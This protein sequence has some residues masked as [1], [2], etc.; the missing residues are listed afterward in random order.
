MSWSRGI[1]IYLSTHQISNANCISD[2]F[3][4]MEDRT[5]KKKK[6]GRFFFVFF[7][8]WIWLLGEENNILSKS[9][10]WQTGLLLYYWNRKFKSVA[11]KKKICSALD[12]LSLKSV[13]NLT[14]ITQPTGYKEKTAHT[15]YTF[16]LSGMHR[17]VISETKHFDFQKV[18]TMRGHRQLM[19]KVRKLA[20]NDLR[21]HTW[22][23]AKIKLIEG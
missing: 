19:R 12:I 3:L 18:M 6:R 11:E 20:K 13:S 14:W 1:L 15:F 5:T 21:P 17:N 10:V 16:Y 8:L 4:G 7:L 9:L 2:T 23:R 22:V